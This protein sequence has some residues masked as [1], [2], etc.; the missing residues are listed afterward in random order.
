M[1]VAVAGGV[2]VAVGVAVGV[3]VAVLVAVGVGVGVAVAVS[4]AVLVAVAVSVGVLVAV[5]VLVAVAVGVGV[6]GTCRGRSCSRATGGRASGPGRAA[7]CC[8]APAAPLP[9]AGAA[10]TAWKSTHRNACG[11]APRAAGV[12]T[13]VFPT[14]PTPRVPRALPPGLAPGAAPAPAAP[15]LPVGPAAGGAR[16]CRRKRT[17]PPTAPGGT[18][19]WRSRSP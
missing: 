7:R 14:G 2:A 5:P 10:R 11:T 6:G 1:P 9:G 15:V 8:A 4:V 3:S 17:G 19:G 18:W 12:L 13:P 16:R